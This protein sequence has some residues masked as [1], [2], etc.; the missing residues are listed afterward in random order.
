LSRKKREKREK[1]RKE[2]RRNCLEGC[3]GKGFAVIK[4]V[5]NGLD[6]GAPTPE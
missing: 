4:K 6:S 3:I 2:E 1:K 5:C